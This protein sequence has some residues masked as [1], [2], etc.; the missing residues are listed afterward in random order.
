[1][2]KN[3]KVG[4]SGV[5]SGLQIGAI[6]RLLF[7]AGFRDDKSGQEELQIRA[8]LGIS[9]RGKEISNQDRHYK[10]EKEGL[11]IRAKITNWDR[12]YK[13]VQ[14]KCHQCMQLCFG[15]QFLHI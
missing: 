15:G 2:R 13:W 10:T 1:M 12:D 6:R 11:E 14:K 9:N 8:G 3:E 5:F 7:G 4:K